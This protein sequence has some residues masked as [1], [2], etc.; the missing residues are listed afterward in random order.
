MQKKMKLKGRADLSGEHIVF[1][2]TMHDG[3]PFSMP[4]REHDVV[5]Q[6]EQHGGQPVVDAW[7]FVTQE[8][9][10]DTRCYLT[11]P[12]PTL[13]FGKQVVVQEHQLMP[14]NA[15]LNDFNPKVTGSVK[16]TKKTDSKS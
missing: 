13:Q 7:L 14:L 8:A 10:Q 5:L 11:L 4:V 15:S 6:D 2:S 1:S 9:K 3:T 12:Q 16:K